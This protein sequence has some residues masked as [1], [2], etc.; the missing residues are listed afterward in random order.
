MYSLPTALCVLFGSHLIGPWKSSVLLVVNFNTCDKPEDVQYKQ[1][2][3]VQVVIFADADDQRRYLLLRRIPE[4]GGFW[5]TV[6]GSLESDES[7]KQAAVREVF[8]ETGFT[9]CEAELIELGIINSFE[10]APLWREKYA[11]GVSHNEE[12]CF[13]LRV[14][15]R[16]PRLDPTEHDSYTWTYYEHAWKLLYWES[17]KR[18]F[19][20]A[21][22]L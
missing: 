6:T 1:P 13:A 10:I 12:I 2:R 3:S 18:A 9:A 17:T 20:A 21:G 7:H 16:E 5:Q 8:E 19:A 11:P 14:A 4:H 15:Q 22:L